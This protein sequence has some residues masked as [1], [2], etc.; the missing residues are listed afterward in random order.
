MWLFGYNFI[1]S[2]ESVWRAFW[3]VS[4]IW[5]IGK[6]IWMLIYEVK[7]KRKGIKD[8]GECYIKFGKEECK[9]RL[10]K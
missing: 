2:I 9:R 8:L 3:I 7:G 1:S 6:V 10:R 5:A 4:G